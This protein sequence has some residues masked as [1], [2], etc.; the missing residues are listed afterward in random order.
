MDKRREFEAYR[1]LLAR[2]VKAK[3]GDGMAAVKQ[4][5]WREPRLSVPRA[6]SM[7]TL[8]TGNAERSAT[9]TS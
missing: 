4:Y 1:Q 7:S 3:G 9:L 6:M 5:A 8:L 2:V